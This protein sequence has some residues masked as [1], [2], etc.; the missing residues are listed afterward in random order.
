ME[1]RGKEVETVGKTAKKSKKTQTKGN[2]RGKKY[3]EKQKTQVKEMLAMGH[4]VREISERTKI[5]EST[6]RSWKN[7][8][9]SDDP[10]ELAK[11]R[12]EK[13][14]E[15]AGKVWDDAIRA[16]TL[17]SMRLERAIR[18]EAGLDALM[19]LVLGASEEELDNETRRNILKQLQS[20]RFDK[21]SD[22]VTVFGTMV[23][24]HAKLIGDEKTKVEM[25]GTVGTRFEDV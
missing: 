23:D 11:V 17:L 6:I 22:I 2:G 20:M 19:S 10:D 9:I 7:S 24:K 21:P 15:L 5:P 13:R 18:E 14:T 8:I 12:A 25:S 1:G 16:E 3:N 4:S